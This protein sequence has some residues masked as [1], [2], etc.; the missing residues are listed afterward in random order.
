MLLNCYNITSYYS[1][2]ESELLFHMKV[3]LPESQQFGDSIALPTP[4]GNVVNY[5]AQLAI[6]GMQGQYSIFH[7]LALESGTGYLCTTQPD[8]VRIRAEGNPLNIAMIYESAPWPEKTIVNNGGIFHY[9][10]A[11]SLQEIHDF[12]DNLNKD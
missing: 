11:P 3:N 12:A 8:R 2:L 10:V 7:T 6:Q 4:C 5:P 1:I 9:K